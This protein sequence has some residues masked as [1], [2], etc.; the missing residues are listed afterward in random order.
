MTLEIPF[1]ESS[2]LKIDLDF[3]PVDEWMAMWLETRGLIL[4]KYGM[5]V[6]KVL[7]HESSRGVNFFIHVDRKLSDMEI[8]LFQ[9]LLGDDPTRCKINRWRIDRG[10]KNWNKIFSRKLYRKTSR[11]VECY[12]CGNRI[13]IPKALKE[14]AIKGEEIEEGIEDT[15]PRGRRSLTKGG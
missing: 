8:L 15:G 6:L 4:A 3:R 2:V 13:L 7:P 1:Q 12:Y 14:K 9:F 11:Y 10:V 5:K